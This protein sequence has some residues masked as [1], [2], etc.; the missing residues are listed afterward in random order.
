[1]LGPVVVRVP[2][3][4]LISSR[5]VDAGRI[6]EG[7]ATTEAGAT[8]GKSESDTLVKTLWKE[9]LLRVGR[10]SMPSRDALNVASN[11]ACTDPAARML[12]LGLRSDNVKLGTAGPVAMSLGLPERATDEELTTAALTGQVFQVISVTLILASALPVQ[13]P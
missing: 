13:E 6:R 11:D 5:K 1:M 4:P 3:P 2:D 12:P 10:L 9:P 8:G 7:V